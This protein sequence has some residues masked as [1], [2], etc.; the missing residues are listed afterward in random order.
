MILTCWVWA[1]ESAGTHTAM[2][3]GGKMWA[4]SM[5]SSSITHTSDRSQL[6][7]WGRV[8]VIKF[9]SNICAV[10]RYAFYIFFMCV[11]G[12]FVCLCVYT[13]VCHQI[14]HGCLCCIEVCILHFLYVCVW[15]VCVFMCFYECLSSNPSRMSVLYRS[16][17]YVF[18]RVY[19]I[20]SICN[21]CDEMRFDVVYIFCMCVCV[22]CV[23]IYI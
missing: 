14:R 9:V 17:V 19:V 21:M 4:S 11:F 16:M 7:T 8:Y 3:S 10:L 13:S 5:C 12:V 22:M 15:C 20:K 1:P 18:I 2:G 6:Y 23:N